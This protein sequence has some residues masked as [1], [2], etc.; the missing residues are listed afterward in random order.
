MN[1]NSLKCWL[2]FHYFVVNTKTIFSYNSVAP[3]TYFWPMFN[4]LTHAHTH[5]FRYYKKGASAENGTRTRTHH[6]KCLQQLLVCYKVPM[7]FGFAEM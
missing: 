3:L 5:V 1:N 6:K 4:I 2:C 7:E